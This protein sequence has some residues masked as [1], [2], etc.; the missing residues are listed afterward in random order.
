MNGLANSDILNE[1]DWMR[2]MDYMDKNP[3]ADEA[4]VTKYAQAVGGQRIA[5]T[6]VNAVKNTSS[7]KSSSKKKTSVLNK[8]VDGVDGVVANT[9]GKLA[10]LLL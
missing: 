2:V 7:S 9:F 6:V 4:D 1:D 5:N 3:D 8:I 10:D